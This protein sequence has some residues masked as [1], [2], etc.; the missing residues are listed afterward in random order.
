[1]RSHIA[2]KR[3][4]AAIAVVAGSIMLVG[5]G[6]DDAVDE[7]AEQPAV[8]IVVPDEPTGCPR[9]V[10]LSD[11][12]EEVQF[13]PGGRD[14]TDMVARAT[15]GEF[16]GGCEYDDDSVT[17]E[18]SLQVISELGP[19]ARDREARFEYFVAITDPQNRILVKE[20]FDTTIPFP[21]GRNVAGVTEELTQRIPLD[22]LATGVAYDI[23]LGFQLDDDQLDFNRGR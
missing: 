7:A 22:Q 13:R 2:D 1:M 18:L 6:S 3:R 9:V 10:V 5:C 20:V 21:D 19:A 23:V 4:F 16:D 15:F 17:V 14:L 11:A 12:A 8:R